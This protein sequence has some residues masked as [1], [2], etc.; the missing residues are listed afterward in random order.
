[1]KVNFLLPFINKTGGI[2]VVLAHAL[3]L[4]RMGHDVA[5]Y[6]PL[7]PYRQ[8]LF[9]EG[10][11]FRKYVLGQLKP[12]AGNL[13][14]YRTSVP[15][16]TETSPVRPVPWLHDAFI[17]DADV[18][19]ATAWPTAYD[20]ARLS[21]SK[22]RKFYFVQG[23][24]IWKSDKALVDASYRLP[25]EIITISPWL[26][27][28]MEDKFG[29]KPAREVCNGIDLARYRP[30]RD[31]DWSRPAVLMIYHELE[32]KGSGDGLEVLK[33]LH[34]RFPSMPIRVFGQFPFREALPFIEYHRDPSPREIVALYQS[35]HIFLCPSHNE[36]WQLPPME[37]M[38]CGCAVVATNVGCIPALNDGSNMRV[39]EARDVSALYL[40]M[41]ALVSDEELLKSVAG[42]GHAT[43]RG[44]S[45]EK[46]T[47]NLAATL[48]PG[49]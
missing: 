32:L 17:R 41:E 47:G 38:A 20:V 7:L 3:G 42:A 23:Y 22:G 18:T 15:W 34:A 43:I 31:R 29:R 24:E 40:H 36:G 30:P 48:F 26:T 6:Y 13:I 5:L 44:Y 8:F 45:W 12:L 11:P 21:G 14:R 9:E 2:V 10:N 27:E 28:L 4:R 33:R 16:A 49:P 19:L 39:A 37:A 1:V 25:L 35:S 46:S